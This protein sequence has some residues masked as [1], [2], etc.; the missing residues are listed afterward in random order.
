MQNWIGSERA[1]AMYKQSQPGCVA[2][3]TTEFLPDSDAGQDQQPPLASSVEY[4]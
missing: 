1:S 4:T 3:I 2:G